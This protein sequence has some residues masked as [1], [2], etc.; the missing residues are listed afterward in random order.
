MPRFLPSF[1]KKH[2]SAFLLA[3]A[4]L[5][6]A[7]PLL[8][9]QVTVANT[10]ATTVWQYSPACAVD[11]FPDVPARPFL[12]GLNQT[13]M[14]FAANST[15]SYASVGAGSSPDILAS[16]QRGTAASGPGCVSWL[17]LLSYADN[18]PASYDNRLWMVA[19]FTPDGR[20]IHALV[21]NEFHGE[22]AGG[23]SWCGQQTK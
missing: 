1:R 8:A 11:D 7:A 10:T 16:L 21:H 18:T 22:W 5:V 17:P 13:V 15:G 23:T 19:P 20:V 2:L 12:V 9:Q 14:W 6:Q 4:A 3:L